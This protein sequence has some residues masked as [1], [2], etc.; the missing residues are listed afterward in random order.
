MHHTPQTM[1]IGGLRLEGLIHR[2]GVHTVLAG[3]IHQT[4]EREHRGYRLYTVAGSGYAMDKNGLGYRVFRVKGNQVEQEYV[5][6]D[7]K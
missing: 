7:G 2:Y 5:R 1:P 3:H 6:L 4:I